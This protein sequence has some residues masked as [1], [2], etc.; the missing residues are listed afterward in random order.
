[1]CCFPVATH[2][3]LTSSME[4]WKL[5]ADERSAVQINLLRSTIIF[6]QFCKIKP[7]L[8]LYS[9]GTHQ[10]HPFFPDLNINTRLG[11]CMS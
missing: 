10:H 1:M 7:T 2:G 5:A 11:D 8:P 9:R 3:H 6:C 4:T